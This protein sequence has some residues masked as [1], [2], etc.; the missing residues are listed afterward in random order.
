[1]TPVVCVEDVSFIDLTSEESVVVDVDG[2][3]CAAQ[4]CVEAD[5]YEPPDDYDYE[6]MREDRDELDDFG[7]LYE[8]AGVVCVRME[9]SGGVCDV[10][11]GVYRPMLGGS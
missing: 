4:E 11:G 7:C 9:L 1:M 6:S 8:K 2:A 3:S 5:G 10:A